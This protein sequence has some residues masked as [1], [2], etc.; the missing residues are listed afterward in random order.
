MGREVLRSTCVARLGNVPKP[1]PQSS[2]LQYKVVGGHV[3]CTQAT[4]ETIE[5]EECKPKPK[6][7]DCQDEKTHK[8]IHIPCVVGADEHSRVNDDAIKAE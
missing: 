7:Y 1:F 4:H 2:K 8:G 6:L 3:A 5:D